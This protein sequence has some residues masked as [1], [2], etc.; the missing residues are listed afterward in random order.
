MGVCL[1]I[2]VACSQLS[3]LVSDMQNAHKHL[4][5]EFFSKHLVLKSV[6]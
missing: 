2:V 4:A 6:F 3:D 1:G 5:M